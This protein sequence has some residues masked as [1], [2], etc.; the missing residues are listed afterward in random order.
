MTLNDILHSAQGGQAV[1]NLASAN[2][3]SPEEAERASQAMLPAFSSAFERLKGHP[4]AL[5]A[6]VAELSNGGHDASYAAPAGAAGA[7]VADKL[8]GSPEAVRKVAEQVAQASGVAPATAAAMLPE[9]SSILLGGLA[10]AMASQNLK[11]VLD[12]LAAAAAAPGGLGAALG[13]PGDT[14]GFKGMLGSLFGGSP[15]PA[16]PQAAALVGGIAALSAMF[17]AGVSA[18][19]VQQASLAAVAQATQPPPTI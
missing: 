2:G 4:D 3:L 8:F 16:D 19:Q 14:G 11:G 13:H 6:L 9:V 17:M 10:H 1:A 18:S 12:D 7:G 5:G 15:K